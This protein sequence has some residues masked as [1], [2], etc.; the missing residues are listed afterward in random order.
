MRLS[1]LVLAAGFAVA[2]TAPGARA[3]E[4]DKLLPADSDSVLFVNVKQILGSD[5]VKKYALEQVKQ[6]LAGQDAKDFLEQL[7][8]DP[9]KDIDKVWAG[10]SGKELSDLKALV[11]VHGQFDPEKLLKAAE[12]QAK[13]EAEKFSLIKDGGTTI[14]KFQPDQGNPVYGT[15]VDSSTI[16]VGTEKKVITTAVKQAAD[17]KAAPISADLTALVKKMDDKAS[18]FTTSVV[19]GK[20]DNVK[21]P[22][23]LPIDLSGVEKALPK[24]ETMSLIVRVSGDIGLEFLFG[25]KDDDAASDMDAAMKKA[26]DSIKGLITI[27]A[28]ADPKAKPL[29]EVFKTIKS[30]VKKKDV[31][32]TGSVTGDL[33]GKTI[34][35]GND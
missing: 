26:I 13:K 29:V 4:P 15:V 6:A 25:M 21:V 24:T 2:L 16:I 8:L 32:I 35:N 1:R 34:N 10:T 12:G 9:L 20:L 14:L 27:A 33:I 23:Q 5:I 3:A 22:A 31:V 28:A 18:V 11:I 7:G 19:K 17:Q 30:D